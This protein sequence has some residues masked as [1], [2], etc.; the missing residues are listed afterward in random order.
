MAKTYRTRPS[1]IYGIHDEVAAYCF[2]R[3]VMIFGTALEKDLQ[4]ASDGAKSKQQAAGREQRVFARW[5]GEAAKYKDPA[6]AKATPEGAAPVATS[7]AAGP[8]AL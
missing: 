3:A 2:D 8:V 4:D 6:A 1:A 7:E 5:F